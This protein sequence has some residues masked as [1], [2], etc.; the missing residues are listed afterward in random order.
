M[1]IHIF[2]LKIYEVHFHD[3]FK[4]HSTSLDSL[5]MKTTCI[6]HIEFIGVHKR[7]YLAIQQL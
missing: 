4:I 6:I 2:E 1:E 7:F 5:M 3:Q